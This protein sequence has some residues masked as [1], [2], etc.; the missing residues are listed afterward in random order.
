M[1]GGH[2]PGPWTYE[3]DHTHRQYNIRMMGHMI[4]GH[5]CTV[6]NLPTDVLA[7][8]D[9]GIAAAN[10]RLI[11]AAPDLLAALAD[12]LADAVK[13]GLDDSPVWGSLIVA[14]AALRK[15]GVA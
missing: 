8:R 11:A 10:A 3:G 2:T 1:T 5:I 4:G 9:P 15:A 6:N 14:R 12:L 7:N 13:M